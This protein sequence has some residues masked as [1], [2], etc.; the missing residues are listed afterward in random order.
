LDVRIRVIDPDRCSSPASTLLLHPER[1]LIVLGVGCPHPED[2]GG[3]CHLPV[4]RLQLQEGRRVVSGIYRHLSHSTS[5]IRWFIVTRLGGCP[6]SGTAT[7][8][9]GGLETWR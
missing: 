8:A 7:L 5:P 6:E 1:G 2:R 9:E 4:I 3:R